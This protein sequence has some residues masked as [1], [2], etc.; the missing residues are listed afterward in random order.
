MRP[1]TDSRHYA[2][3]FAL[4]S[5]EDCPLDFE[6][7]ESIAFDSG[8]LLPRGDSWPPRILLLAGGALTVVTHPSA[9]EP[10][11]HWELGEI[12]AVE[13]GHMLLKGWLR[14]A[15]RG[16]DNTIRYNTRGAPAVERFLRRFRAQFLPSA[17]LGDV[18]KV[19]CGAALDIKFANALEWELD[20]GE[21][22]RAQFF[23]PAEHSKKKRLAGDL[24]TLTDRRL[25]WITDRDKGFRSRYGTIASYAPIAKVS[26]VAF[27]GEELQV[28]LN[29]AP[30][31]QA[32]IE[33]AY[34]GAAEEFANLVTMSMRSGANLM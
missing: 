5:A 20:A 31:W 24:W 14:F 12:G 3:A 15:G 6:L 16:F 28:D 7:P 34:R 17:G 22:A 8:I 11:R 32:P 18:P 9:G 21:S 30:A 29:G 25:L 19:H 10:K 26:R 4:R 33:A 23:Q 27:A 1:A 13:S 2:I